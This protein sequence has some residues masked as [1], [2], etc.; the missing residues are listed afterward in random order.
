LSG[1][2]PLLARLYRLTAGFGGTRSAMKIVVR[3]RRT[4][5][6]VE[7]SW[8]VVAEKGEGLEIPTLAAA[9]LAED[10]LAGRLEPGA[11]TAASLLTLDRFEPAFVGLA[12]RHETDE[13]GLPPPLYERVLGRAFDALPP[14][15]RAM[16]DLCGDA[17]AAGAG[18]VERGRGLLARLVAA[19]MRFPPAGTWPLRLAFTERGGVET[20]TR[21]FGGHRFSSRLSAARGGLIEERFGPMRFAFDLPAGTDG[22][23]MRLR[24]WSAFRIPMPGFLAPR[25]AARE[26]QDDRGRFRFAVAVALPLVGDVVGYEGWLLPVA[27]DAVF[28]EQGDVPCRM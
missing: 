14:A 11:R 2:A 3:G 16:H 20:W 17:G 13:R 1:A 4:G 23:E 21:D 25:I 27:G 19:I 10:A 9:L 22:L 8:T 28:Q 26:W 7:R 6:A 18:K 15:V 5:L 24:R 12:V